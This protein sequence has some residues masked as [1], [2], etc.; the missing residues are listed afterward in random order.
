MKYIPKEILNIILDYD[1]RIKYRNGNYINIIHKRDFRYYIIE[2]IIAMKIKIL[3]GEDFEVSGS[4][5]YFEFNIAYK[6]GLCY[7][8]NFTYL[9][10]FEICYFNFRD[11]F[12]QIR[13]YIT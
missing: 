13:T 5:F 1:G 2:P 10:E 8:Y 9:N 7:D 3:N 12:N 11:G 6:I 4:G